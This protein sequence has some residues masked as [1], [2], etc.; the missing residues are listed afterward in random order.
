MGRNDKKYRR[1]LHQQVYDRLVS[2]QA[3]GESKQCARKDG[4]DKIKIFS[5]NT[6]KNYKRH[7]GY[8]LKYLKERHPEVS[9]LH[10]ARRYVSEWLLFRQE[11]G[12]SPYT[13]GLEKSALS[14]LFNLSDAQVARLPSFSRKRENITRSRLEAKKDKHFSLINNAELIVFLKSTGLT[15]SEV[16]RLKKH[17]LFSTEQVRDMVNK[18][19]FSLSSVNNKEQ[20][21]EEQ[22]EKTNHFHFELQALYDTGMFDKGE[23]WFVRVESRASIRY[24]PVV[25]EL[26]SFVVNKFEMTADGA[27]V[28]PRIHNNADL[29]SYRREYGRYIY[30]LYARDLDSIPDNCPSAV[31]DSYENDF[32]RCRNSRAGLVYDRKALRIASAAVGV[33]SLESFVVHYL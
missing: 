2:M 16:S 28:F 8:F 10:Q 1:S 31:C 5:Y 32:Y 29:F 27:N 22:F 13:L 7:I 4:S 3:F 24:A 26:A 23:E 15:R 21:S 14:K 20:L 33:K 11:Q 25:G 6:Y 30:H 9:T 17:D 19:K 12:L 18:L